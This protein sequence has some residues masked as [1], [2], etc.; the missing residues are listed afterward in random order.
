METHLGLGYRRLAE[1]I[2][3]DLSFSEEHLGAES[4]PISLLEP[5]LVDRTTVD[6]KHGSSEPALESAT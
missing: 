1:V 2:G 3:N 6:H 5:Q 4:I